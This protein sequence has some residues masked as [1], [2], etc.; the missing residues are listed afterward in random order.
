MHDGPGEVCGV[1]AAAVGS[2]SEALDEGLD[3]AA[4]RDEE[5]TSADSDTDAAA[6]EA[7]VL[8]PAGA[9]AAA[10]GGIVDD[11]GSS[12]VGV[13]AMVGDVGRSNA[14]GGSGV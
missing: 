10:A 9:D 11:A 2:L 1:T 8:G 5:A 14:I 4:R 6:G 12:A 3:G 13:L 7:D